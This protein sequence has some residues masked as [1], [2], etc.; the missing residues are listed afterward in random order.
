M[1]GTYR[2][3]GVCRQ[4]T[5]DKAQLHMG[6]TMTGEG[7]GIVPVGATSL[8]KALPKGSTEFEY[9][10]ELLRPGTLHITIYDM[11]NKDPNDNAYAGIYLG[12]IVAP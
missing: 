12:E 11:E 4:Q 6:N 10:F 8:D 1:G 3:K 5:L 2:V 9:V 7:S